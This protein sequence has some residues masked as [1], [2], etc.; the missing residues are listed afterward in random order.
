M[1]PE[2][3]SM[4][5]RV[6]APHVRF[7]VCGDGHL[8]L[9]KQQAAEL[10]VSDRFEF[11]GYVEDIRSI[12]EITDVYGYPLCLNPG[13]ELNL[14]EAMFAGI[15]PV[16]FPLG[17]IVD[18]VRHRENGMIVHNE[19]EYAQAIDYL[20]EHPRRRRLMGEAARQ[21]AL[22]HFGGERSAAKLHQVYQ[23]MLTRP[24]REHIWPLCTNQ[25][26][27]APH[28][29]GAEH[30]VESLGNGNSPYYISLYSQET[31]AVL[32]ADEQLV[33]QTPL[34]RTLLS[35][36]PKFY[37][38]DLYLPYWLGLAWQGQG[39]HE[40][41]AAEFSRARLDGP[42]AW[43]LSWR[44]AQTAASLGED[45]QAREFC[46]MVLEQAPDFAPAAQLL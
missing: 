7:I 35:A 30:F 13:A 4:S 42:T 23:T 3:V 16:V 31:E 34:E 39:E 10:D 21:F 2:F 32:A 15:P 27:S 37:P 43:R 17:G 29:R 41:A 14:Q 22:K 20:Y 24:K 8:D 40:Q 5:A 19:K 26:P 9:L 1:H 18:M 33:Q 6:Q 25:R 46:R 11:R 12:L 38:Q 44:R 36:Y 45:Q 28:R